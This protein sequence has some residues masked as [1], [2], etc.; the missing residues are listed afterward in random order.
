MIHLE[1]VFSSD[2]T[3]S[4]KDITEE[5]YIPT[6]ICLYDLHDKNNRLSDEVKKALHYKGYEF[7]HFFELLKIYVL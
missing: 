1:V 7:P 6:G 4:S 3:G 5:V 2:S